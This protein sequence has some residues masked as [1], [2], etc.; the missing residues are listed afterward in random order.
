MI[1]DEDMPQAIMGIA[2]FLVMMLSIRIII[3]ACYTIGFRDGRAYSL[4]L[5]YRAAKRS[6]ETTT[7]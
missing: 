7:E 1:R 5:A 3:E 6:T 2:L 4:Y